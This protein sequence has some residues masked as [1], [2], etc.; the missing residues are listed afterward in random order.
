MQHIGYDFAKDN[1]MI[2]DVIY[3][4]LQG[5]KDLNIHTKG[6]V[7]ADWREGK[8]L[9]NVGDR[10]PRHMDKESIESW[11]KSQID[12]RY[13]RKAYQSAYLKNFFKL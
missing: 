10:S 9:L 5:V 8:V 1:N 6:K 2:G 12:K 7:L 3:S 13:H 4:W 11:T